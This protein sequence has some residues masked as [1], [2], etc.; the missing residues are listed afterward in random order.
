MNLAV[1]DIGGTAV[2]HAYYTE[3]QLIKRSFFATP[4]TWEEMKSELSRVVEGYPEIDGVAFSLPGNVQLERGVIEGISAIPYLHH[5]PIMTEL[6][7][8]FGKPVMMEN[9]ANS[10][11][12][13]E[14]QL[15][16]AKGAKL[17]SFLVIGTGLGGAIYLNG[18]LI[19]G[20]HGYAGEFGYQYLYD[21]A[22]N[23]SQHGSP[24]EAARLAGAQLGEELDGKGLFELADS[25][26]EVAR[27]IVDE[28][29]DSL[30]KGLFNLTFTIDPDIM[31]VGG[32]ISTNDKILKDVVERLKA[33]YREAGVLD[34]V[35]NVKAAQFKNDANLLGAVVAFQQRFKLA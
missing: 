29:L 35:P 24:V 8:L 26:D 15:G 33:L 16:A 20:S 18:E 6:E 27:R 32:A 10:A 2:K 25:G 1:F 34:L 28:E 7:E 11:G 4:A 19:R 13:A 5:F 3:E 21:D 9:D 12:L 17:A 22:R 23:W 31:I 14:V 30:A